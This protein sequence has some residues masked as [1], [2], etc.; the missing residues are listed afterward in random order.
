MLKK[1]VGTALSSKH[2][3]QD[4]ISMVLDGLRAKGL[5][6]GEKQDEAG[7]FCSRALLG[8]VLYNKLHLVCA[9]TDYFG[10]FDQDMLVSCF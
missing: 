3:E 5:L 7:G 9:R 10:V 8:D 4:D 6:A 1:L 2:A